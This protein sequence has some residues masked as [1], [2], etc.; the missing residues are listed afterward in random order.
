MWT[1]AAP[2]ASELDPGL[3][4]L[5]YGDP[6]RLLVDVRA[7]EL[8]PSFYPILPSL[9]VV[10][11]AA[12]A[13]REWTSSARDG[14]VVEV[15]PGLRRLHGTRADREVAEALAVLPPLGVG[16][17]QGPQRRDDALVVEVLAVELVQTRAV[18]GGAQI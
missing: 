13:S 5:G 15:E 9:P 17:E 16:E 2:T 7:D 4:I 12:A 11:F 6:D 14:A 18:E 8:D 1:A 10:A 3:T